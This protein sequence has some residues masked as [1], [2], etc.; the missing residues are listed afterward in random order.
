MENSPY[1]IYCHNPRISYYRDTCNKSD[2]I[3]VTYTLSYF[4][5]PCGRFPLEEARAYGYDELKS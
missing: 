5:S 4:K 3:V 1:S 2:L